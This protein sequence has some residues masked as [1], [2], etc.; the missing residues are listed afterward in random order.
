MSTATPEHGVSVRLLRFSRGCA[1]CPRFDLPAV[2]LRPGST[3]NY[4]APAQAAV[5]TIGPGRSVFAGQRAEGFYVD[6]G[7]I[8]DLGD[9]GV[10]CSGFD[11]GPATWQLSNPIGVMAPH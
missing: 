2:R 8:F 6:L 3:P 1:C 4:P 7:A 9:L 11:V 5:H 10:L